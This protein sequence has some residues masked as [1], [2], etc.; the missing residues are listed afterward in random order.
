MR[1]EEQCLCDLEESPQMLHPTEWRGRLG[2]V[3]LHGKTVWLPETMK[4][5][6]PMAH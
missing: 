6:E 1:Q 3:L 2:G 4:P 5:L